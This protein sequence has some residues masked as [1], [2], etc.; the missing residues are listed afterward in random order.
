MNAVTTP[1]TSP[2]AIGVTVKLQTLLEVWADEQLRSALHGTSVPSTSTIALIRELN[3]S[4]VAPR[5][6]PDRPWTQRSHGQE[7]RSFRASTLPEHPVADLV[8]RM[9]T[10]PYTIQAPTLQDPARTEPQD[11]S[12][13]ANRP[14]FYLIICAEWLGMV[15]RWQPESWRAAWRGL[16]FERSVLAMHEEM[17]GWTWTRLVQGHKE[18][19]T[20]YRGRLAK[21]LGINTRK[22]RTGERSENYER[23]L[24]TAHTYLAFLPWFQRLMFPTLSENSR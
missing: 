16:R 17:R 9:L 13:R 3:M 23:H 22:F 2:G 6:A 7:T 15:P 18:P 5:G 21:A 1:Q 19:L 11:M 4:E 8:E 12:V 10:G 14:D 20:E 24:Y